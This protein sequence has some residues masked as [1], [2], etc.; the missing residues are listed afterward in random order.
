[1]WEEASLVEPAHSAPLC[2][3]SAKKS[4]HGRGVQLYHASLLSGRLLLSDT[5]YS[6]MYSSNPWALVKF[7]MNFQWLVAS[8]KG[9]HLVHLLPQLLLSRL[10]L[11]QEDT[12]SHL[13]S[14]QPASHKLL[15]SSVRVRCIRFTKKICLLLVLKH[16]HKQQGT[17][18]RP[19]WP[20]P[21]PPY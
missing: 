6:E 2:T 1:M 5:R 8:M 17:E 20:R 11:F 12:I 14:C 4:K 13:A 21:G 3:L 19:A 18:K 9:G 7:P 15:G 10:H 16:R